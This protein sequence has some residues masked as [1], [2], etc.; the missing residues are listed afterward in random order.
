MFSFV[1]DYLYRNIC[2]WKYIVCGKDDERD[3]NLKEEGDD[4]SED[5]AYGVAVNKSTD[6]VLSFFANFA[7]ESSLESTTF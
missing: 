6:F 1:C 5:A 4:F 7:N 3:Q 2:V